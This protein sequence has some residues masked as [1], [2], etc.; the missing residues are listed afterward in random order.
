MNDR[1]RSATMIAAVAACACSMALTGAGGAL[2]GTHVATGGQA[3][4][5]GGTWGTAQ[6][7]PGTA[8]LTQ[9]GGGAVVSVSCASADNCSAGGRYVDG[10]GNIQ[11]FVAKEVDGTWQSAEQ[12]PGTAAL[13]VNTAV[14]S[15]SCASVGNCSA[16]GQYTPAGTNHIESFVADEVNGTWQDAIEVPGT[17]ALNPGGQG[18]GVLSVSCASAGNCSAGGLYADGSGGVQAFVA[19]EVN[20]TWQDAV[21]VPGTAALNQNGNA[22]LTSVSCAS[23]GNCSAGGSYSGSSGNQAFAVKEVNGTWQDAIEVP[24]IGTLNQDD[25]ATI[26]TVSCASAGKCSAG[27]TYLDSANH[28]QVFVA[29]EVNGTWQDAI[30]VPGTATLNQDGQAELYSVSC[31]AAGKCSAG[32]WYTDSSGNT[33]AFA[34][35]EVNGTWQDA[36]EVP[37]TA[38]LNQDGRA[39]VNTVSCPVAGECSAAGYYRDSSGNTQAFVANEVNGKW[40]AAIEVPGTATLN[41]GGFAETESVSC[42]TAGNCSAGGTYTD[43]NPFNQAFVV[44]ET[45]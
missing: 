8:A 2:A 9:D 45:N 40:E 41:Q 10:N 36:I 22:V 17:A 6:E 30:E 4:A 15:V 34:A 35:N 21:E 20:G 14:N 18:Q 28:R 25:S 31:A 38:T 42:A 32:G 12:I 19:N 13:G 26:N 43:S 16:G 29:N 7:V 39:A 3:A 24:G 11:S 23:A 5:S 27:G 33:Q 44:N 37:G 1:W